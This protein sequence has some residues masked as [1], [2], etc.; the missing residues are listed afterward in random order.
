MLS[1][2]ICG[3]LGE[4]SETKQVEGNSVVSFSVAVKTSIKK[5]DPV[6]W[7]RC[8]MWGTRATKVAPYL[9]KGKAVTVRGALSL[10]EYENKQGQTKTSVELR[11]DDVALQGGGDSQ[12]TAA[13]SMPA[14]QRGAPAQ[15]TD[16]EEEALPF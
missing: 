1:A 12:H 3:N 6:T 14:A 5:E 15:L 9:T 11:V 8:S 16:A 4:N 10:R 2:V 13:K 7:V